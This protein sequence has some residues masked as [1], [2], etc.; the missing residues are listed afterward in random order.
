ME[1]RVQQIAE[2]VAAYAVVLEP[3]AHTRA[4]VDL[5][6]LQT[7]FESQRAAVGCAVDVL[8]AFGADQVLGI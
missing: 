3:A 8:A 2:I 5:G 1:P 6:G 4:G 7:I